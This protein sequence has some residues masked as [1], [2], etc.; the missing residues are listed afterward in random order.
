[1]IP[2]VCYWEDRLK[3]AALDFRPIDSLSL[4]Y[5]ILLQSSIA[6]SSDSKEMEKLMKASNDL[7]LERFRATL[8]T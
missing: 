2:K 1:V 8:K 3:K 7:L 5:A 6:Q 4:G